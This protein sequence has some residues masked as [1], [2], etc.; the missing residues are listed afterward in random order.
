MRINM[1]MERI[2]K[3]VKDG[4]VTY[5]GINEAAIAELKAMVHL[6]WERL[7]EDNDIASGEQNHQD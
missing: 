6:L 2:E 5:T 7:D 4:K 3:F 1:T